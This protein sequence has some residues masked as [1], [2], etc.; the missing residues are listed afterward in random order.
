MTSFLHLRLLANR[1]DFNTPELL[2]CTTRWN[3]QALITT[4]QEEEVR[5]ILGLKKRGTD[6]Y[7]FTALLCLKTVEAILE[8]AAMPRM[9]QY[10]TTFRFPGVAEVIG[11][12]FESGQ[13]GYPRVLGPSGIFPLPE[14]VT[15]VRAS[16]TE[17]R[18]SVPDHPDT[19]VPAALSNGVLAVS[20]PTWLNIRG[21]LIP[22]VDWS[23]GEA[24]VIRLPVVEAPLA[25]LASLLARSSAV[26]TV[27]QE[28]DLT[29]LHFGAASPAHKVGYVVAALVTTAFKRN[30][31]A[32]E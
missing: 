30:K 14:T 2:L 28:A 19:V 21:V 13:D 16:E 1:K 26:R 4:P 10:P 20:W 22:A 29:D 17:A 5:K 18:I 7:L 32:L 11:A 23:A 3:A 27:L 25:L 9:A 31:A 6:A 24:V 12:K 8:Q 15:L